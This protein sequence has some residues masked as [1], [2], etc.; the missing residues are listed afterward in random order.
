MPRSPFTSNASC[1]TALPEGLFIARL[2]KARTFDVI[3]CV[4]MPSRVTVPEL[5]VNVPPEVVQLPATVK[6]FPATGAF[7]APEEMTTELEAMT[8]P[9]VAVNVPPLTVIVPVTVRVKVDRFKVPA[10]TVKALSI[11]ML[12][13]DNVHSP[14]EPLMRILLTLEE[15]WFIVLPSNAPSKTTVSGAINVSLLEKLPPIFTGFASQSKVP[16]VMLRSPFTSNASCNTA[17]SADLLIVR[18]WKARP[19]DVIFCVPVPSRVTVP[20]LFVN[21]P[22]EVVQL[23]VTVKDFPEPGAFKV[24]EDMTTELS[25]LIFPLVAVNVPPS[26]VIVPPAVRVYGSRSRVPVVTFKVFDTVV[27]YLDNVHLLLP[28]PAMATL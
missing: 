26:T 3:F 24:P 23:P 9:L 11:T 28:S 18:L 15:P 14:P 6:D 20:E 4:P 22:P 13:E 25:A 7:K 8:N 27:L 17:L 1:N 5:F 16:A 21:V 12:L 19:F 2:W 10:V